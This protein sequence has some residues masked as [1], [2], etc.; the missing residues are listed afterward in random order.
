L[1]AVR[2]IAFFRYPMTMRTY[3]PSLPAR[4]ILALLLRSPRLRKI[5]ALIAIGYLC[6]CGGFYFYQDHYLFPGRPTQGKPYAIV[7]PSPEYELIRFTT[8]NGDPIVALFG[9]ALD[10]NDQTL[11]DAAS[12]PTLLYFYGNSMSMAEAFTEFWHFRRLGFNVMI[13]DYP[14]Y[15]MSGGKAS[16][17]SFDAC[18]QAAFDVLCHRPDVDSREIVAVGWSLGAAVATDLAVHRP[19]MGLATFSAFTSWLHEVRR[20]FFWLPVSAIVRARFDNEAKFATLKC[21]VFIAHGAH[22][23]TVPFAMCQRLAQARGGVVPVAVDSGHVDIFGR[24]GAGLMDGLKNFVE[25]CTVRA[26][27]KRLAS[28][29]AKLGGRVDDVGREE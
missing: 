11:P 22:D 3:M 16:E 18:A 20:V 24:G 23:G 9:R 1:A 2:S 15:G 10:A 25:R 8:A 17:Q 7:R 21:P 19:V 4:R 27:E 26:G 29:P 5:A 6:L 13:P 12:R 14:G 28:E